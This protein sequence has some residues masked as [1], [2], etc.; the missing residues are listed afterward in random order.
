MLDLNFVELFKLLVMKVCF[1]SLMSLYMIVYANT[2]Y[3]QSMN[4]HTDTTHTAKISHREVEEYMK[5]RSNSRTQAAVATIPIQVHV[6]VNS[7]GEKVDINAVYEDIKSLN[8]IYAN[9]N[10]QFVLCNN[11]DYIYSDEFFVIDNYQEQNRLVNAYNLPNTMDVFYV[12]NALTFNMP[13]CGYASLG[14]STDGYIFVLN[15]CTGYRT[16][17]HEVGHYLSLSHTFE[18]GLGVEFVNGTNCST[19]GDLVCDTPADPN[20]NQNIN[21]SACTYSGTQKDP[22]GDV[23]NP[24]PKNIMSYYYTSCTSSLTGGQL[25]R[26]RYYYDNI[27][28]NMLSCSYKPDFLSKFYALPNR[29]VPGQSNDIKFIIQNFSTIPY[30]GTVNYKLSLLDNVGVVKHTATGSLTK[31]FSGFSQDTLTLN[32]N[33]ASNFTHG[34]YSLESNLDYTNSISESVENNN[35]NSIA[36]PVYPSNSTISD[37]VITASGPAFAYKGYS[38]SYAYHITNLGVLTATNVSFDIF[39][40]KDNVISS[41]DQRIGPSYYTQVNPGERFTG[42]GTI[43]VPELASDGTYFIIFMIDFL[44]T[45]AESNKLNNQFVLPVKSLNPKS[46]WKKPDL[47]VSSISTLFGTDRIYSQYGGDYL[48]INRSE[49]GDTTAPKLLYYGVYLSSDSIYSSNDSLIGSGMATSPF[50]N[51]TY[52]NIP[53]NAPLGKCYLIAYVDYLNYVVESNENNNTKSYPITVTGSNLPDAALLSAQLTKNVYKPG[54][55]Y[56][57]D[58]KFQNQGLGA[59]TGWNVFFFLQKDRRVFYFPFLNNI[60]ANGIVSVSRTVNINDSLSTSAQWTFPSDTPEGTYYFSTCV[61][62]SSPGDGNPYNNCQINK[63]PIIIS[64]Q[65]IITDTPTQD[66][67]DKL[68]DLYPNPTAGTVQITGKENFIMAKVVATNGSSVEFPVLNNEINIGAL[69][70]GLY[71]V[72]FYSESTTYTKKLIKY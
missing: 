68:Y 40:S 13:I 15:G 25:Q 69:D 72:H 53:K 32:L 71:V 17:A 43:T 45:I 61:Q 42:S 66:L 31:T 59:M 5:S 58:Y 51:Y 1:V 56:V 8:K 65:N 18:T 46:N 67:S 20:L 70:A 26:A 19:T 7:S 16:L 3:S 11:I 48:S 12:A 9:E 41:D 22:N 64:R 21:Y 60:P 55:N 44:N 52:F 54:D 63:N 30:T 24:L 34:I 49:L 62:S 57:V 2:L 38:Y 35:T 29:I 23:Y 14:W 50:Y 28:A 4:C 6:V 47:V 39:L 27:A 33:L 36:I 37:L 10:L